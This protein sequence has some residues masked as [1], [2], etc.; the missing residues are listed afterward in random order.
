[1][2]RSSVEVVLLTI[3]NAKSYKRSQ[4]VLHG[5]G[6]GG[7]MWCVCKKII[8]LYCSSMKESTTTAQPSHFT[9]PRAILQ[10]TEVLLKCFQADRRLRSY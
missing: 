8:H 6:G 10:I 3:S 5:A 2:S 7:A 9:I 1:M 4:Y